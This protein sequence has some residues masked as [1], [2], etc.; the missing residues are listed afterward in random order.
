MFAEESCVQFSQVKSP[1]PVE[2]DQLLVKMLTMLKITKPASPLF[3]RTS[4]N[5]Q[6]PTMAI[7]ALCFVNISMVQIIDTRVCCKF[8]NV[9]K[10]ISAKLGH[11]SAVG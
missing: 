6:L 10:C 3:L 11:C 5:K 2:E 7:R 4:I 1:P 9:Y 8:V